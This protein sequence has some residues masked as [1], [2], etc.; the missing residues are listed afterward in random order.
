[1]AQWAVDSHYTALKQSGADST[2]P[3]PGGRGQFSTGSTPAAARPDKVLD[4][5]PYLSATPDRRSD[6]FPQ[7]QAPGGRISTPHNTGAHA[8]GVNGPFPG[9]APSTPDGRWTVPPFGAQQRWS[10]SPHISAPGRRIPS[11]G[12]VVKGRAVPGSSAA[13]F[14][15]C[16]GGRISTQRRPARW[17]GFHTAPASP[18]TEKVDSPHWLTSTAS[19]DKE[20][21][22]VSPHPHDWHSLRL[23]G[24]RIPSHTRAPAPTPKQD[25]WIPTQHRRLAPTGKIGRF[26]GTTADRWTGGFPHTPTDLV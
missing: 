10:S 21:R 7:L 15:L 24:G 16:S 5:I 4:S 14:P 22:A 25:W 8:D 12:A 9:T 11:T 26:P 13:A 2:A 1:M 23:Q 19:A 6:G 18:A 3:A 17:A 20:D